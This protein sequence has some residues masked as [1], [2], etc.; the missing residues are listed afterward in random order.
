MRPSPSSGSRSR[1]NSWSCWPRRRYRAAS[2]ARRAKA[3]TTPRAG[4]RRKTD[5]AAGTTEVEGR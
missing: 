3:W 5:A 4:H 1:R 2:A